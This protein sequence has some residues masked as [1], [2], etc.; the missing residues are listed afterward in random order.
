VLLQPRRLFPSSVFIYLF[1][2]CVFL[3]VRSS[4]LLWLAAEGLLLFM[5]RL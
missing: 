1:A 4:V 3:G 5:H 2:I